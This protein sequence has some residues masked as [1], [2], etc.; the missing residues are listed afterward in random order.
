MR[1]TLAVCYIKYLVILN[2]TVPRLFSSMLF[3]R[4]VHWKQ[5]LRCSCLRSYVS[6]FFLFLR[7]TV[8]RLF[9]FFFSRRFCSQLSAMVLFIRMRGF[10][11]WKNR[12]WALS[13]S[14]SLCFTNEL[15]QATFSAPMASF[16]GASVAVQTLVSLAESKEEGFYVK[17]QIEKLFFI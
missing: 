2:T 10:V 12:F 11:A 14:F 13:P 3:V 8:K 7:Y 1:Y 17:K 4:L 16:P 9:S 15:D 5:P 6:R